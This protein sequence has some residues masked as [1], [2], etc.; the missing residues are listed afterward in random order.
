[1]EMRLVSW[2]VC[3][4]RCSLEPLSRGR[5]DHDKQVTH[6]HTHT[7]MHRY[8]SF[9]RSAVIVGIEGTQNV[10]KFQTFNCEKL[11]RNGTHRFVG[12]ISKESMMKCVI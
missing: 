3:W 2:M 4:R 12:L 8:S 6:T 10:E 1:M 9:V 5:E 11:H 7:H